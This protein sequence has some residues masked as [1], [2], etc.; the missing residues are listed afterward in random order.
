MVATDA[1]SS[2]RR[3]ET[4]GL[5]FLTDLKAYD[6]VLG[7]LAVSSL[8]VILLLMAIT[9]VLELPMMMG[10]VTFRD[11]GMTWMVLA[12]T[13]FL[14]LCTA[15]FASA[16]FKSWRVALVVT[17]LIL[18]VLSMGVI[19]IAEGLFKVRLSSSLAGFCYMTCPAY[20]LH[21]SFFQG[22][23]NYPP[24]HL[25][26][27][28]TTTL[29][30]SCLWIG[31]ACWLTARARQDR[32]PNVW[33]AQW[34]E[35]W[36]RGW[37]GS[38]RHRVRQRNAL[39][40]INP[41]LWLDNRKRLAYLTLWLA[42][43]GYYGGLFWYILEI[44][45]GNWRSFPY[46]DCLV[47]W[48]VA[49]YVFCI[50]LVVQAGHRFAE[51]RQSGALELFLATPLRTEEYLR[52][53]WLALRSQFW[54]PFALLWLVPMP[55]VLHIWGTYRY[56][57]PVEF[58]QV[59]LVFTVLPVVQCWALVWIALHQGLVNS[60]V[61]RATFSALWRGVGLAWLVTGMISVIVTLIGKRGGGR[62]I[63]AWN[64]KA[65][66]WL[67]IGGHFA[68][69][70]AFAWVARRE[71]K[72]NFRQLAAAPVKIHGWQLLLQRIK[73]RRKAQSDIGAG[74]AEG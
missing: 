17:V 15:I 53:R 39:L 27:N 21:L 32:E 69:S 18:W 62:F 72:Q 37:A 3:N 23:R 25:W 13:M 43:I 14:S 44:R 57:S 45:R 34:R 65:M 26:L 41:L 38:T 47:S 7:K 36:R 56:Q 5:L 71:L 22:A 30:L 54:G 16:L 55:F 52:G 74:K 49:Y 10:G 40:A 2:E 59:L 29:L 64:E 6:V 11:F 70:L 12:N 24:W 35:K 68:F 19:F 8:N 61:G 60:S 1:L 67:V 48:G 31:L 73:Q 51:D 42:V 20:G 66:T 58:W 50:W 33:V 63:I 9:P 46:P 28:Q 4:L